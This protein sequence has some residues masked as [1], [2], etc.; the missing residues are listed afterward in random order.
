M[1]HSLRLALMAAPIVIG[2]GFVNCAEAKPAG[3]SSTGSVS[4]TATVNYV[5]DNYATPGS[6]APPTPDAADINT[7]LVEPT[8]AGQ[9]IIITPTTNSFG[10]YSNGGSTPLYITAVNTTGT[11]T[12]TAT[13][14]LLGAENKVA[15]PYHINYTPC[16]TAQTAVDLT[17]CTG[18]IGCPLTSSLSQCKAQLGSVTYSYDIPTDV[19]ADDYQGAT[20]L[21]YSIGM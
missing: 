9:T 2:L 5:L 3:K 14:E 19:F 8:N 21:T 4:V 16:G 12:P 15:I 13:P 18:A 7:A 6:M 17:T 20:D 1:K 10:V 11:G